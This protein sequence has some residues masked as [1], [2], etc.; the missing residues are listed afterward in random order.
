MLC[1]DSSDPIH[2]SQ[3]NVKTRVPGVFEIDIPQSGL[4][5]CLDNDFISQLVTAEVD[6]RGVARSCFFFVQFPVRVQFY[7]Q[8][9]TAPYLS[10]KKQQDTT[11]S[12]IQQGYRT[13]FSGAP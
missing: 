12:Q 11:S 13:G 10:T 3:V 9:Y 5:F 1:V 4:E 2:Q 8:C 6:V 7:H